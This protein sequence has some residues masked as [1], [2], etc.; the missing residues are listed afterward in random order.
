MR[1]KVEDWLRRKT[2]RQNVGIE[3]ESK[4]KHH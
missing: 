3:E 2:E 1:R 4:R